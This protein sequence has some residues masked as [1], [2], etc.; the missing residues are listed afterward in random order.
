MPF[1]VNFWIYFSNWILDLNVIW[2]LV[3]YWCHEIVFPC[4]N[5]VNLIFIFCKSILNF[6]MHF[7]SKAWGRLQRSQIYAIRLSWISIHS[8]SFIEFLIRLMMTLISQVWLIVGFPP[9]RLGLFGSN[10]RAWGW[11]GWSQINAISIYPNL[12]DGLFIFRC[13]LGSD[14]KK[15]TTSIF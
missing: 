3:S 15:S 8:F 7:F 4:L 11:L 6:S 14:D 12:T 10:D 13:L 9:D 2:C 1:F 5:Q